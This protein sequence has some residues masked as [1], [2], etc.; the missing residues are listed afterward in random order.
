MTFIL[1]FYIVKF[2]HIRYVKFTIMPR[3]NKSSN[4]S[5]CKGDNAGTILFRYQNVN[6]NMYNINL[7]VISKYLINRIVRYYWKLNSCTISWINGHNVRRGPPKDYLDRI[8][9][10]S[11]QLFWRGLRCSTLLFNQWKTVATILNIGRGHR[12]QIW[13]RTIQVV[14]HQ[15]GSNKATC[16]AL[17]RIAKNWLMSHMPAGGET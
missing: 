6:V 12:I 9:F 13:K 7:Y 8:W 10:H 16:K 15:S 17:N 14:S 4:L 11:I 3:T 2:S 5:I 1:S